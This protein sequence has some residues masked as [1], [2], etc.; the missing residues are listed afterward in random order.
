M[1]NE[2]DLSGAVARLQK[3][4]PGYEPWNMS[5]DR[6][7]VEWLE[8]CIF[9]VTAELNALREIVQKYGFLDRQ[10]DIIDGDGVLMTAN[11]EAL[12]GHGV[13]HVQT[14]ECRLY[15][16]PCKPLAGGGRGSARG[17]R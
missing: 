4:H 5:S 3:E 7:R 12:S 11:T 13:L 10:L 17:T 9:E 16:P 1:S 15:D 6:E 2:V 14:D 8:R